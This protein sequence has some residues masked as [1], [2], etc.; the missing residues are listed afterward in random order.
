MLSDNSGYYVIQLYTDLTP[1]VLKYLFSS[2]TTNQHYKINSMYYVSLGTL[3]I[4]DT[5]LF[6]ITLTSASPHNPMLIK[7]T[8]ANTSADWAK[9]MSC[10]STSCSIW[11]SCSLLSTDKSKIYTLFP[12]NQSSNYNIYISSF[13]TSDGTIVG[14]RYQST[15][16]SSSYIVYGSVLSGDNIVATLYW[17]AYYLA[18]YNIPSDSFTFKSFSGNLYDVATKSGSSR[19]AS[20]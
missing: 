17:T 20:I 12:Y 19:W 14:N 7:L 18:I 5:E 2:P 3:M 11:F 6:W 10:S 13:E 4:S 16:W 15:A 1:H 8:F 9:Q